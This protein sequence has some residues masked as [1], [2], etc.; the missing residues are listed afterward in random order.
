MSY[1]FNNSCEPEQ[2]FLLKL[3]G[4]DAAQVLQDALD[5]RMKTLGL[6]VVERG[7][8]PAAEDDD[9]PE[10]LRATLTLSDGRRFVH[11]PVRT[12]HANDWGHTGYGYVLEG[13]D[14]WPQVSVRRYSS[15]GDGV[16]AP[17]HEW[18]RWAHINLEDCPHILAAA[19]D[20]LP[21]LR[22]VDI[23]TLED[24]VTLD[25]DYL[26]FVL[27]DSYPEGDHAAATAILHAARI[28]AGLPPRPSAPER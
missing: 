19:G 23:D 20:L 27:D 26:C 21:R 16:T 11:R 25:V 14:W 9:Q 17:Q 1:D 5:A 22:K 28:D 24:I 2:A 15:N 12:D 6:S 13:S 7:D 3:V 8:E 18:Q 4:L 10:H